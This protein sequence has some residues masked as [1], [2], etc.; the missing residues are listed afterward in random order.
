[1]I[2]SD[3]DRAIRNLVSRY[4]ITTDNA[5]PDG[6]M[7]CW[8]AP[9]DFGGYDSGAFGS[10]KTWQELYEFEKHHVG[11]GGGA[12]GKRHQAGN[13]LVEAVSADEAHVTHDLI[14]LEVVQEPRIIATGRYNAS[15]VVRT[16]KGWRFKSRKLQVDPGYFVLVEQW[17][18]A[19]EG[20]PR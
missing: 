10:M 18:K 9:E 16:P 7:E 13:V 20:A 3:D 5:D 11:P 19:A 15:V 4:C 6:F 14:V 12:N 8:V 2:S 17:K 1:M